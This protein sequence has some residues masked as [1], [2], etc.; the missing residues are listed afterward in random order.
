[1]L[2]FVRESGGVDAAT[3][4]E[5]STILN[6]ADEWGFTRIRALA[7]KQITHIASPVDII[8]LGRHYSVEEVGWRPAD[9][10]RAICLRPDAL[11]LEEG[12][13]L[14]MQDVIKI[15]SKRQEYSLGSRLPGAPAPPTVE[16]IGRY[17]V[18]PDGAHTSTQ[19]SSSISIS[20]TTLHSAG[21]LQPAASNTRMMMKKKIYL[22]A[23]DN[24]STRSTLPS[25]LVGI[26]LQ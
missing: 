18:L 3:V 26:M 13:L 11:T 7:I 25:A 5:W 8:V 14:G 23:P 1:M 15:M 20:A 22:K 21:T 6:L 2:F 19:A 17:F 4:K 9:A 24:M 12:N 10:Y 16:Q